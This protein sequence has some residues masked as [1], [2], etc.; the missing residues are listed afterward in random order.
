MIVSDEVSQGQRVFDR[1]TGFTGDNATRD[2]HGF[3]QIFYSPRRTRR[4]TEKRF[5]EGVRDG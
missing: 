1:I 4:T 3:S 2:L 5:R